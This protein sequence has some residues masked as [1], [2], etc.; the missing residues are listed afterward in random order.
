MSIEFS[1]S[2][3]DLR[4]TRYAPVSISAAVTDGVTVGHPCCNEPDCKIPLHKVTDE[5][6][7]TH[8]QLAAVCCISGCL[9]KKETGHRTCT[10]PG[11]RAAESA[12]KDRRRR[13][14]GRRTTPNEGLDGADGLSRGGKKAGTKGVF[15]RKW[16]HNEQL[17]V[18]PCG[19][20]IGR[21][22]FYFAESMS[23]V[24]VS[25]VKQW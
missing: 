14:A 19:V 3:R 24:K 6:C 20:V 25:G 8:E 18:R 13:K 2:E 22:T 15:S 7:P 5:Y 23:G 10:I 9:E 12:K 4:L 16:T 21:A 1:S 17:M 11:H